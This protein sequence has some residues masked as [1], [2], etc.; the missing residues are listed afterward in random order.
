[1]LIPYRKMIC[2][3][4]IRS[5]RQSQYDKTYDKTGGKGM[6]T[7]GKANRELANPLRHLA[8]A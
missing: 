7:Q 3:K 1:M 2:K 8:L 5:A 6:G 4:K